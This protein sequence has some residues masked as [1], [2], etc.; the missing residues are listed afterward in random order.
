MRWRPPRF[1]ASGRDRQQQCPTS[2]YNGCQ[3]DQP[4]DERNQL[5]GRQDD[6]PQQQAPDRQATHSSHA[7][8]KSTAKGSSRH[9]VAKCEPDQVRTQQQQPKPP[10]ANP[11]PE[12]E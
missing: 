11:Q 7:C 10:A 2:K 8:Q 12:S 3:A 4:P 9:Q 5:Q 6:Q 1:S